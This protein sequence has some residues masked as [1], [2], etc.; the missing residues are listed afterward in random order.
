[1]Q[2]FF[3]CEKSASLKAILCIVCFYNVLMCFLFSCTLCLVSSTKVPAEG[4]CL[5]L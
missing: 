5:V 1:M 2:V 4:V 3:D